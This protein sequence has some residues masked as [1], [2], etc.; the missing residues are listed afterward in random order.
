MI[1]PKGL[2]VSVCFCALSLVGC[3]E[4]S[5]GEVRC[6]VYI[7]VDAACEVPMIALLSDPSAYEGIR[8]SFVGFLVG[9]HVPGTVYVSREAWRVRDRSSAVLLSSESLGLR[10]LIPRQRYSYVVVTGHVSEVGENRQPN[11]V[12]SSSRVLSVY[13]PTDFSEHEKALMKG[14]VGPQ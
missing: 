3:G 4:S 7:K 11:V 12:V 10:S 1:T 6:G 5:K 9:D 14:E 2:L 8:I 13:T